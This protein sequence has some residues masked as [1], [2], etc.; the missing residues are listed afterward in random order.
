MVALA[1]Q[2]RPPFTVLP[3]AR[4]RPTLPPTGT[5]LS[6]SPETVTSLLDPTCPPEL[7]GPV[8]IAT[9]A[10]EPSSA[11]PMSMLALTPSPTLSDVGVPDLSKSIRL[12]APTVV[13]MVWKLRRQVPCSLLSLRSPP[14]PQLSLL[15]SSE[16][17]DW[18]HRR[19]HSQEY[20]AASSAR[21]E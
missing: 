12:V 15:L 20:R 4:L 1:P 7:R 13:V 14:L 21:K 11:T 5:S 19:I 17:K 16:K 2:H 8:T 18:H 6:A 3:I 9:S 10:M